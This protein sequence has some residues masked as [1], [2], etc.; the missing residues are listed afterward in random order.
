MGTFSFSCK[1]IEI[2]KNVFKNIREK[3]ESGPEREASVLAQA[4]TLQDISST[5]YY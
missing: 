2:H 4:W 3:G 5:E 1:I